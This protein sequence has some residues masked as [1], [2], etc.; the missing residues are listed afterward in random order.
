MLLLGVP[1]WFYSDE[2]LTIWLGPG[3]P[4]LSPVIAKICLAGAFFSLFD[5][6][7]YTV[8][9]AAGR[10]KEN[11]YFNVVGGLLTFGLVFYLVRWQ[12]A[13]LASVGVA[14]SYFI[15][16]G[17]VF[18]PILLHWIANYNMRDFRRIF[19]PSFEALAICAGIGF[20]VRSLMPTGLFWAIPSCAMIGVLNA[21]A[22]YFL[23]APDSM[24]QQ[25]CRALSKVPRYGVKAVRVLS[26]GNRLVLPLRCVLQR[27]VG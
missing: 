25:F 7:L 10:I 2:A 23:V 8:L 24:Q 27:V 1:A 13:P 4:E 22:L 18:K 14:A 26:T 12:H 19:I 17:C 21:F 6:S 9:Y 11:M 20:A 16:L 15:L 3:R 5:S